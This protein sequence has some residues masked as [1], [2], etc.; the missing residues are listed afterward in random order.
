MI[1]T[2]NR[3]I[4]YI[5]E[6]ESMELCRALAVDQLAHLREAKASAFGYL[7]SDDL[8]V[9]TERIIELW[10]ERLNANVTGLAPEG[11]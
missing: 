11:D 10:D 1:H 8:I 7:V 9:R 6:R 5:S 3:P 4:K 2:D